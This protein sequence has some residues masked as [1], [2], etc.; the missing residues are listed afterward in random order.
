[1]AGQQ[2][3]ET[4]DQLLLASLGEWP[5]IASQCQQ[6]GDLG[7]WVGLGVQM[8]VGRR[9]RGAHTKVTGN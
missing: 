7:Q 9:G 2:L 1:M 6:C 8:G 5:S 4:L 3:G